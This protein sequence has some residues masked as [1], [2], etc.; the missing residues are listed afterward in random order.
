MSNQDI[1]FTQRAFRTRIA[2]R[3]AQ[4]QV[5]YTITDS[6][7]DKAAFTA[8]YEE[9]PSRFD[10]RTFQV[11][12][13]FI[14][15]QVYTLLAVT[16]LLLVFYPAQTPEVLGMMSLYAALLLGL[17]AALR[18]R[19]F[20]RIYTSLPTRSGKL[21]VL[22]DGQ[23]DAIIAALDA[24]RQA[25]LRRLANIGT[26]SPG[27]EIRKLRL[28][29]QE[30]VVSEAEFETHARTL[31]I[32]ANPM[33]ALGET[34]DKRV[35]FDQ[36]A[37]AFTAAFKF[38]AR[39]LEYSADD[40]AQTSFNLLYSDI[41]PKAE[42]RTW[43]KND[44]V[45]GIVFCMGAVLGMALLNLHA[46][47]GWYDGPEGARRVAQSALLYLPL[48]G[49]LVWTAHMRTRKEFTI[50]PTAKGQMRI[51][52][53]ASHDRIL[54]EMQERRH[55]AL[56][57]QAVI[58]QYNSPESELKKFAWLK[59]QGAITEREYEMFRHK[60]TEAISHPAQRHYRPPGET[61]H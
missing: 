60:L 25:A 23:H 9:L 15:I 4:D 8:K 42:C 40:G 29:R 14:S 20:K 58:D 54:A 6:R 56:R 50:V 36:R 7:G 22:R 53:D 28:L 52:H 46:A 3:L 13:P 59:E 12:R 48:L 27:A 19:Y 39:H 17:T 55:A 11:R 33:P 16:M 35:S 51:L 24:R 57:A 34:G 1:V 26:A 5:G 32:V 47:S 49:L 37:Y 43:R 18:R 61:L 45:I 38:E 21:L 41:P 30:G 10:Y 44:T 31:G 2:L